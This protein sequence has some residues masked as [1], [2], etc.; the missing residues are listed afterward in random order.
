MEEDFCDAAEFEARVAAEII[1][2]T[3]ASL[4]ILRWVNRHY[5]VKL[6]HTDKRWCNWKKD[7][8]PFYCMLLARLIVDDA[9][10]REEISGKTSRCMP[11]QEIPL[12]RYVAEFEAS[13]AACAAKNAHFPS[14]SSLTALKL[15]LLRMRFIISSARKL[16]STASI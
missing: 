4:N 15:F 3:P 1:R 8:L 12:A 2:P 5:P 14:S 7:G 16:C 11:E 9:M 6:L 13:V 10:G